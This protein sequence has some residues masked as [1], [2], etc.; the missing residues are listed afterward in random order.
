M[1]R[2][3]RLAAGAALIVGAA[4][5]AT[6][7]H[8]RCT[9]PAALVCSTAAAACNALVDAGVLHHEDCPQY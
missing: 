1:S 2:L 8:A 4:P 5:L 3:L 6:A 7:S 9:Q